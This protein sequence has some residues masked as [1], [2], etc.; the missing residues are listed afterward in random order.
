M[1]K[2]GLQHME[3]DNVPLNSTNEGRIFQSAQERAEKE[4][5]EMVASELHKGIK[6]SPLQDQSV[7][8]R[9]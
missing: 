9:I 2:T 5:Q 1:H 4:I 3:K 8:R 7:K 6:Y